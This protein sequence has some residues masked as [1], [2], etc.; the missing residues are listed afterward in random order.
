MNP[1]EARSR[2][3]FALQA[4]WCARLSSPF[5]ARLCALLGER[6]DDA[7]A[8]G[9]RVLSWPGNPDSTADAV[10]LRLAGGLHALVRRGRLPALAACYPP[11]PCL[12]DERLWAA[13][14][15]ALKDA[16][17]ELL[18]W[19]D[20]PPQTNEV[21]RSA[22]LMAGLLCVAARY[23]LPLALYEL[24]ASAGLNL[25]L[26]RYGYRLGDREAGNMRSPLILQPE[27][28]GPAPPAAQVNI[29]FRRGVDLNPLDITNAQDRE[30]LLAYVWP[31]QPTRL[32]QLEAAIRIASHDPPEIDRG[33]AAEWLSAHLDPKPAIGITR[34]VMYSISYQYFPADV[35][36]RI[37]D[38]IERVGSAASESAPFA[39]LRY[40]M[41]P[42]KPG[43]PAL[44]LTLWPN[45]EERQLAVGHPHVRSLKWLNG[46]AER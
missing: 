17:D 12:D 5:T 25:V 22:A 43:D 11:H 6:L 39:W 24:G 10:P 30:R 40:E 45:G 37:R 13:V 28:E 41:N 34:V 21:G 8:T 42:D 3:A 19:L 15:H 33:D 14:D 2:A 32:A 31:D 1:A 4:Q 23:D 9:R 38:H 26:D 27:W 46:S 44:T 20:S 18:S 36:A 35:Q 16:D 7:T 29:A